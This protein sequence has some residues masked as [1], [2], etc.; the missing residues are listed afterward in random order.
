M[1]RSFV[2]TGPDVLRALEAG[3]PLQDLQLDPSKLATMKIAVV[4]VDGVIVAYW[5][6]WTALHLE[7]LWITEEFRKSPSVVKHLFLA[8][9][10]A[11]E[12][13][14]EPAAFAVIEETNLE[15]VGELATRLGFAPAPGALYYL[16]LRTPQPQ[17]QET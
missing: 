2:L 15:A 6:L 4:E 13:T 12:A 16:V 10:N 7:P 17:E 3:G 5:V 9:M 1:I 11:A 8:T 14:G